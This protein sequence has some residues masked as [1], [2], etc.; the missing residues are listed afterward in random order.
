MT[1]S[2][3]LPTATPSSSNSSWLGSFDSIMLSSTVGSPGSAVHG[4]HPASILPAG[5][6]DP[7]HL[8]IYQRFFQPQPRHLD[9]LTYH[10]AAL[11]QHLAIA[12]A[13]RS[14]NAAPSLFNGIPFPSSN[15]TVDGLTKKPSSSVGYSVADLLSENQHGSTKSDQTIISSP[16]DSGMLTK[17]IHFKSS[18]L[19]WLL[20]YFTSYR[21]RTGRSLRW[22]Y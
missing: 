10:A 18:M 13:N 21:W 22:R 7:A 9:L 20:L 12:A 4:G 14:L 2:S 17:D 1:E 3:G 5:L 16:E 8:A 11:H 15:A 19:N 6:I